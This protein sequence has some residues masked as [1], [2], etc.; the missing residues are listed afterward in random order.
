MKT[1]QLIEFLRAFSAFS[2][3]MFH[4][5]IIYK[6]QFP[7][8]SGSL[9]TPFGD[10]GVHVFFVISG[11]VSGIGYFAPKPSGISVWG[12][13]A[14][15]F[16][17]IFP[18]LWFVVIFY[19]LLK[20]SL[21]GTALSFDQF[22]ISMV[23]IPV[24]REPSPVIVWTLRHILLFYGFFAVLL[25]SRPVGL[26]LGAVW[27][28]LCLVQT[29]LAVA[30]MPM[31]GTAAILASPFNL[32]LFLGAAAAWAYHRWPEPALW[33]LAVFGAVEAAF[34]VAQQRLGGGRHDM[35]DY[36]SVQAT[37]WVIASGLAVA[38]LVYGLARADRL[39]RTPAVLLQIGAASYAIYLIHGPAMGVIAK[40]IARGAPDLS[41]WVVAAVMMAGA[42]VAGLVLHRWV[43]RPMTRWLGRRMGLMPG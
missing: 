43:E 14:R 17:R 9:Y 34:L 39:L 29:A 40:L 35:L 21:F 37:V 20:I 19:Y 10:H 5:V 24:M 4:C 32:Q 12:F 8:A 22:L 11:F 1:I 28:A 25:A 15:R 3:V 18:L 26:G 36:G 13:L 38:L 41:P 23:P 42:T 33:P 27:I 7:L 31:T 30:G 2:I 6:I 16:V